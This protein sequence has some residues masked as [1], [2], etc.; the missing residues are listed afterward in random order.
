MGQQRLELILRIYFMNR[1]SKKAQAV[2]E[3][4]I[5]GA[6]LIFVIGG[7]LRNSV[8]AGMNQNQSLKAM[9]WAMLQSL[10]GIRNVNKARD[11][12]SVVFVEDRLAP[13]AG[14]VGSIERTPIVQ[15]ATATFT[16]NMFMPID[17]LEY[18]NIALTDLF[19]NGIHFTLSTARFIVYDIRLDPND[20]SQIRV[21]DLT[22]N[23]IKYYP[24]RGNWL[25]NCSGASGCPIFYEVLP[26]NSASACFADPC[27]TIN[28]DQ[29]FDLNRNN[30]YTDDPA[31][32]VLRAQMA[33]Q[34]GGKKGLKSE[35]KIDTKQ[36]SFPRF[37]VDADRKDESI[38]E[39]NPQS[40]W[41]KTG[42]DYNVQLGVEPLVSRSVNMAA[43]QA[44]SVDTEVVQ[45][46]YV[47]DTNK[48]DIDPTNDDTDLLASGQTV[49]DRGLLR[50]TSVYS[51]TKDGTYLEINEGRAF[52][53]SYSGTGEFVRSTSKKDLIDVITRIYQL[54]NN[55][56]RYCGTAA[57]T[58]WLTIGNEPGGLP[59]PVQY[60]VNTSL[61]PAANCFT[62]ATVS[63]TCYDMGTKLLF[64]RS[65][66][67]DKSGRRW[68]T[69]TK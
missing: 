27:D 44:S 39:I 13:E 14:K 25:D 30:D 2:T 18:Q 28:L 6:I 42:P 57:G 43:L 45:Q 40:L 34:W 1:L 10:Y 16:T 38:F 11:S 56:G 64:I 59:N 48:G 61:F 63:T 23:E 60:C 19:V 69:Q 66:I 35:L 15:V 65:R 67:E 26:S 21:W 36:G 4:A 47:L 37:D 32:A 58:R 22:N 29:R 33:W 55:T 3:L 24:K 53:P 68:V 54:D 8:D 62:P 17:W 46:V 52:V 49:L 20:A 51:Q 12:S 31:S 9:R 5:F 41:E 7:I 50:E